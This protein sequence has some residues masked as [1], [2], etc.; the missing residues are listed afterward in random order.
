M[1]GTSIISLTK[2]TPINLIKQKKI[3]FLKKNEWSEDWKGK[4]PHGSLLISRLPR[5]NA[6]GLSHKNYPT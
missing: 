6:M 2:I 3:L 4:V 5:G 1:L